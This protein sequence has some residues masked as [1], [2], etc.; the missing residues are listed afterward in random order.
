MVAGFDESGNTYFA[1]SADRDASGRAVVR[2]HQVDLSAVSGLPA[3]ETKGVLHRSSDSGVGRVTFPEWICTSPG[4]CEPTPAEVSYVY[5]ASTVTMKKGSDPIVSKDRTR[6]VDIVNRYGLF[7]AATGEVVSGNFGFPIRFQDARN[8]EQ[9]GYYGT[10]QGRHQVWTNGPLAE[11]TSVT[12]G[13][14]PSGET[15]ATYT[16][17]E[18]NPGVLVRLDMVPASIDD[19]T[20]LHVGT[21]VTEVVLLFWD[22]VDWCRKPQ[23]PSGT[24]PEHD[25]RSCTTPDAVAMSAAEFAKISYVPGVQSVV[26]GYAVNVPNTPGPPAEEGFLA[27]APAGPSGPGF[28][29]ADQVPG[30]TEMWNPP[31]LFDP[32]PYGSNLSV[33]ASVFRATYITWN[34]TEW[35]RKEVVSPATANGPP[36]FGPNDTPFTLEEGR[37]YIIDHLGPRYVVKRTA[38]GFDVKREVQSVAN[39]G[40]A[41]SFLPAGTTFKSGWYDKSRPEP[42]SEYRFAVDEGSPHF[43]NLVYV[44][45]GADEPGSGEAMAI[46]GGKVSSAKWGLLACRNG[47]EIDPLQQFNWDYPWQGHDGG[48]Q[49]LLKGADGYVLLAEPLRFDLIALRNG[50]GES[51]NFQLQ[52]DGSWVEGLPSIYDDLRMADFEVTLAIASKVVAIPDGTEVTDASGGKAYV[53]RQLQIREYLYPTDAASLD[54]TPANDLSLDDVPGY[55]APDPPMVA[56]DPNARLLYSEGIAVE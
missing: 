21:N 10:R 6:V 23:T 11:G 56:L 3:A 14:V 28:Y 12:R 31:V 20:G 45:V 50:A 41:A 26:I 35:M 54:L 38:A 32:A 18:L 7:D 5:D 8:N 37:E 16:V 4:P 9:S 13:D 30:S 22:G 34:G 24:T 17:T 33:W 2:I 49:Q 40:N 15:A 1:A 43:M 48:S 29:R 44:K 25:P 27:Y 55:V 39:P 53:F 19:L 36:T 52:F 51:R 42:G 47:V 46:V